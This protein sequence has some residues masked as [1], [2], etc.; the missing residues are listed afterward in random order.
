VSSPGGTRVLGLFSLAVALGVGLLAPSPALAKAHKVKALRVE[1]PTPAEGDV[2]VEQ[3]TT[4]IPSRV[5]KFP[6]LELFASD[7]QALPANVIALTATRTQR[8]KHSSTFRTDVVVFDRRAAATTARAAGEDELGAY[9]AKL[10]LGEE[11]EPVKHKPTGYAG[12][13]FDFTTP[14][15]ATTDPWTQ[16]TAHKLGTF[17]EVGVQPNVNAANTDSR[18]CWALTDVIK[19]EPNGKPTP[20]VT[21]DSFDGPYADP[22]KQ[23][24]IGSA[25]AHL[26]A[27]CHADSKNSLDPRAPIRCWCHERHASLTPPP[28]LRRESP[29]AA[30]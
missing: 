26:A 3:I 22:W 14:V 25:F 12:L 15:P 17:I 19:L 4:E 21:Y 23:N 28:P 1:V 18:T 10:I 6:E 29:R 7:G 16:A 24:G 11:P 2:T 13:A 8:T 20:G 5:A 30:R 27:D 9:T